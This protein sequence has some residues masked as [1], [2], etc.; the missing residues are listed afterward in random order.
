MEMD[1]EAIQAAIDK[2][3]RGAVATSLRVQ[4]TVLFS[5]A[6]D[7]GARAR[8][9]REQAD[10][11]EQGMDPTK[12]RV[13]IHWVDEDGEDRV[14]RIVAVDPEGAPGGE[15]AYLGVGGEAVSSEMREFIESFHPRYRDSKHFVATINRMADAGC[16]LDRR[17][18]DLIASQIQEREHLERA[19]TPTEGST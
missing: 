16:T 1:P 5:L 18:A 12:A 8:E 3:E 7:V 10:K 9:L 15:R 17:T 13:T 2:A 4:A 14:A 19:G 6:T 11:I